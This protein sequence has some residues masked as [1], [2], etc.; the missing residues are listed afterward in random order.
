MFFTGSI[1]IL[2]I[3]LNPT[4]NIV[5]HLLHVGVLVPELVGAG[6]DGHPSVPQVP[7]VVNLLVPHLALGVLQPQTDVAVVNIQSSLVH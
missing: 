2:K 5:E 7:G 4:W 1:T 6:Q 3:T